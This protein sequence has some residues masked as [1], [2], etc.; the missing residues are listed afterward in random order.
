MP[1]VINDCHL[2]GFHD[3]FY[4]TGCVFKDVCITTTCSMSYSTA[5]K[6]LKCVYLQLVDNRSLPLGG[7]QQVDGM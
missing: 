5:Y 6:Q 7:Q 3:E 1:L 4:F 2:I